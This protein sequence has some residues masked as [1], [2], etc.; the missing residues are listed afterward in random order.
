MCLG[1]A[2]KQEGHGQIRL[3]FGEVEHSHG[4]LTCVEFMTMVSFRKYIIV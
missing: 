2:Q 4:C 3:H 1:E